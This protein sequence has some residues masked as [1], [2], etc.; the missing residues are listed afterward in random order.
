MQNPNFVF[1]KKK[2]SMICKKIYLQ[3]SCFGNKTQNFIFKTCF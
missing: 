2:K 1:G 3:K